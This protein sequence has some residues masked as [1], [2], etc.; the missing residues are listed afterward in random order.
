[1][2]RKPIAYVEYPVMPWVGMM[3]FGYGLGFVFLSAQRN[4]LLTGLGS[5]LVAAFVLLRVINSYGD[6]R[7]WSTQPDLI[8]T[9]MDFMNVETY[10]PSL[11]YVWA[12]LGPI[13]LLIPFLDRLK[14]PV[15]EFLQTLGAVPLMAYISHLYIIH[16]LMA[17]FAAG[18]NYGGLINTP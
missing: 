12:T 3:A 17:H 1:M 9:M 8:K 18:R 13:L 11:I 6:P 7:P 5:V 15:A 4:R 10:P 16:S 14:N 2:E